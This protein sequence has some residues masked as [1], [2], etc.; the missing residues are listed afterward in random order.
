MKLR[1]HQKF[2]LKIEEERVRSQKYCMS[3]L[4]VIFLHFKGEKYVL[5]LLNKIRPQSS[6][7]KL[8]S[9]CT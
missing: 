4:S 3:D 2:F 1:E 5:K 6:K 7:K 8:N 9:L